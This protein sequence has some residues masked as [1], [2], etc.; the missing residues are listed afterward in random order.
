MEQL[1]IRVHGM[2][3]VMCVKTIEKTLQNFPDVD[4]VSVNLNTGKV[5]ISGE[6]DKISAGEIAESIRAN[7][8][9]PEIDSFDIALNTKVDQATIG[10]IQGYPG[11][12]RVEKKPEISSLSI[13]YLSQSFDE[14]DLIEK[15]I[16]DGISVNQENYV[17]KE[18]KPHKVKSYLTEITAGAIS[19]TVLFLIM[20]GGWIN[21]Q[22]AAFLSFFIATPFFLYISRDIFRA[23]FN[24]LRHNLLNMD[25]M[26]ALGMGIALGASLLSTFKVIN[27]HFMLYE[28]AIFLAT[29]LLIGRHLEKRASGKTSEAIEKLIQLQPKTALLLDKEKAPVIYF[30]KGKNAPMSIQMLEHFRQ[31][32]P[33]WAS[34]LQVVE[35]ENEKASVAI[36]GKKFALEN[37]AHLDD[38]REEISSSYWEAISTL[39]VSVRN[40]GKSNWVRVLPGQQIAVD[41]EVLWGKSHV[42]EAMI[43][44]EPQAVGKHRGERVFGGSINLEGLLIISVE[45]TGKKSVLGQIIHMV[46]SARGKKA[47]VQKLADQAVAY[48]IPVILVIAFV[49]F[50]VWLFAG[51]VT[52]DFAFTILISILVI[53]CPCALGLATPTAITVGLGR[54]AALGIFFKGGDVFERMRS[55]DTIMFDK[56]GTITEGKPKVSEIVAAN[57]NDTTEVLTLAA[58]VEQYSLHPLAKTVVQDAKDKNAEIWPVNNFKQVDG[59]GVSGELFSEE[60][61]IGKPDWVLENIKIKPDEKYSMSIEEEEKK[62]NTVF[63]VS[64]GEEFKGLFV[65]SDMVKQDASKVIS[66]L[67]E[68]NIRSVMITGDS[69]L[70]ATAVAEKVG[71]TSVHAGLLPQQKA[72]IIEA[73][74]KSGRV[75]AFVGDGTNDAP[76]L[77][78]ADVGMAMSSGTDIAIE[79]GDIVLMR[80]DFSL[81]LGAIQLG[82][83]V[84]KQI[85]MNLFWAFFYNLL[86]IPVAAGLLF[87]FTGWLIKPEFAGMAMA[88]SSVSVVTLSLLMKRY[89]PESL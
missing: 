14:E 15:M 48:F 20:H 72:E 50:F 36:A 62:G 56:T 34:G 87:P 78:L 4:N 39:E 44:G 12:I 38:L 83:R 61:R 88:M 35:T 75:V 19:G 41:G 10:K 66:R 27:S 63:L 40:L 29:F 68:M 76:S 59:K 7:G 16:K 60:I 30:K 89:T 37:I 85:K 33:E 70:T 84:M 69:S 74:K 46:E 73:E 65:I 57:N 13:I 1:Q 49:A 5:I 79:A 53:A 55:I 47:P 22:S 80:E 71:I 28:T 6:L 42:E 81:V 52:F 21:G 31:L 58:S 54:G 64:K 25:V 45:A 67:K 82:Q 32:F 2:T 77:A 24:A 8:Y 9:E 86:L 18:K 26:Y 43:T 3:C 11:V 23:A 51:G 17:F